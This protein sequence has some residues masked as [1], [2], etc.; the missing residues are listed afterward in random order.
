MVKGE[1]LV[2]EVRGV[3]DG[4]AA[5]VDGVGHPEAAGSDAVHRGEVGG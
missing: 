4:G 2:T 3:E 1:V 5:A